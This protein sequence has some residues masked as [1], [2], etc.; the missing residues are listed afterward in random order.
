MAC[1]Y[2][3]FRRTTLFYEEVANDGE[4]DTFCGEAASGMTIYPEVIRMLRYMASREHISA[5]AVTCGPH[6]I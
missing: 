6:L 4:Y 2:N 5:V 1:S 3:T